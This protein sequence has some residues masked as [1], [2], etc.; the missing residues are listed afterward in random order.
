MND[1]LRRAKDYESAQLTLSICEEIGTYLLLIIWVWIAPLA[2]SWLGE[3]TANR[4]L[5]LIL[6][7]VF[8]YASYQISLFIFDYLNGYWLEHKYGLS[9]ETF[10]KWLWRHTK[11]ISLSG[12][13]LGALI[14]ALYSGVW[15]V[16]YWY[17]W[18]WVVWLMLSVILAQLFPVLILPIFY[19]STKL[20]DESLLQRF[21][22]M[23]EGTGISVEGVYSL[24]LSE[25]TKKGNAMLAGLGSTRRVLLSDTLLEKF[26]K[27]QIEVIYAHELGHHV[28]RHFLKTLSLHSLISIVFF[29]LIY[30][31]LNPYGGSGSSQTADAVARLP[32]LMLVLGVFS[33]FLRPILF[34]VSRYFE[35]Q[36]DRYA[37]EK[38]QSP[39]DF[40]SAFEALTDQNLTDPN[41]PA[42]VVFLYHD[43]P[44]IGQRIAMAKQFEKESINDITPNR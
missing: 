2:V 40:I 16:P 18:S 31:I 1:T 15:Y 41:P 14:V 22:E 5:Q 38:T 32:L 6:M 27:P 39:D 9:T 36:S 33:F 12:F 28:H 20:E 42:W 30:L 43:H 44:A 23:S 8:M 34:A 25:S 21:R 3:F 26:T 24:A 11:S 7:G 37:L 13:F 10:F 19:K 29:F 35:R 17:L 4:Y